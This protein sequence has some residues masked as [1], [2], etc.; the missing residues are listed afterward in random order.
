VVKVA[1]VTPWGRRTRCG[2][3][4]YSEK[5]AHA[6]S[7]QGVD[8]YIV[9]SHRLGVK[10]KE[11]FEWL[12]SS[13]I[14][15][16]DLIH[17]M[18]EYGLFNGFEETFYSVLRE[19]WGKPVVTTLHGAGGFQQ[20]DVIARYSD[21]VIVHNK[22]QASRFNHRCVVIPHGVEPRRPPVKRD[23][24]ERLGLQVK[25]STVGWFGFISPHKGL[26]DLLY[27]AKKLP[28]VTFLV[29][30]GWHVSGETGYIARLKR[31]SP[32]NVVWLGYLDDEELPFFFGAC[33]IIVH[34][35]KLVSESGSLL[36]AVGFGK[37]VLARDLPPNR[38]KPLLGWFRDRDALTAM[39]REALGDPYVLR[40]AG[41]RAFRYAVEN[42]W[43]RV[44]GKHID[45]YRQLTN[46]NG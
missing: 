27:A 19:A 32:G 2:V 31:A 25:G 40:A 36:T 14:P 6:L 41:E 35:S 18:H 30:G 13:R 38:G 4:T 44:A 28:L 11:Y 46:R 39:I 16:V 9:R 22:W 26:E 21:V 42:S 34:T 37:P 7:M 45:L 29:C 43:G 15:D 12:A 33:D 10:D 17:V 8:V 5:L 1:L 3:R 24:L 20:D 23:S